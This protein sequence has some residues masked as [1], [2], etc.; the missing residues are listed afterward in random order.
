MLQELEEMAVADSTTIPCRLE[1]GWLLCADFVGTAQSVALLTD[2]GR[3]SEIFI[4]VNR[5]KITSLP[6][7]VA[8]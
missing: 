1:R 3:S 4:S 8:R 5:G 6:W 7:R 2:S